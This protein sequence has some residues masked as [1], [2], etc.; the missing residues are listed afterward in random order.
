[1]KWFRE[2]DKISDDHDFDVDFDIETYLISCEVENEVL[3][4]LRF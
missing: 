2:A 3:Q 1:M 4:K